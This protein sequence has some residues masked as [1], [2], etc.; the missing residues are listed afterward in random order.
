MDSYNEK[1]YYVYILSS[2]KKGTLYIG[3]TNNLIRR[4][5]EHKMKIAEGFTSKYDVINLVYYEIF[6]DV[7]YA[8][9][10]EKKLKKW[11]RDWKIKLIEKNNAE[12]KDLL[13]EFV[14]ENE[15][16]ELEEEVLKLKEVYKERK[17]FM[18]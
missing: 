10:R 16:K 3:V 18:Y 15:L 5:I 7:Y 12:W 9:D 4:V 8:I 13:Y 6:N 11:N 17:E 14:N 2:K 1:F